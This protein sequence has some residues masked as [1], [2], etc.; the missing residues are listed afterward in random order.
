MGI[1]SL[2]PA[3]CS[4]GP[5]GGQRQGLQPRPKLEEGGDF[6]GPGGAPG[7]ESCRTWGWQ[8]CQNKWWDS[9]GLGEA[10]PCSFQLSPLWASQQAA[11]SPWPCFKGGT[12][13]LGPCGAG[14]RW[15][16]FLQPPKRSLL[17]A[18]LRLALKDTFLGQ[19]S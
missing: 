1:R 18:F 14:Q 16:S 13:I 7:C 9:H 2:Q 3:L 11:P 6:Q 4:L 15:D 17:N 10:E 19:I 12:S 8:R 5:G